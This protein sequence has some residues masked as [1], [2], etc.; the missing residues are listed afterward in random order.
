[1]KEISIYKSE[2]K[3][4]TNK[5]FCVGQNFAL[6]I[7]EMKSKVSEFPIVFLK[8]N[9]A[10]ITTGENI[11]IPNISKNPQQEVELVTVIGKSGKN[12]LETNAENFIFGYAVGFDITLRD[13]Q[14][15]AKK[16]GHPW[17]IAKGFDTSSPISEIVPKEFFKNK[18]IE[19][20]CSINGIEKQRGKSTDMI[21][22]ISK[23]ISYISKFFTLE[24]GDLIF[25]G[26]P[27]GIS[28]IS[29][30]DILRAEIVGFTQTQNKVIIEK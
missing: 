21:Y 10:I 8:P 3:N 5:V 6:H 4:L 1:M 9:T 19:F 11:L 20:F 13:L 25:N 15:E 26:T 16:N 24:V 18:E 2:K 7:E 12:I 30:D 22:S 17:T 28:T 29:N 23:I 14:L 27:S